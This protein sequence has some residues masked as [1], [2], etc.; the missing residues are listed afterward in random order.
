MKEFLAFDGLARA[1]GEPQPGP[2]PITAR[3]SREVDPDKTEG[4]ARYLAA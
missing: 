3:A 2:V 4:T 1:A